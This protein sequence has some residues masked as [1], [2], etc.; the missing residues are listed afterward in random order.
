MRV[1]VSVQVSGWLFTSTVS[2]SR[3][4]QHMTMCMLKTHAM[5][6]ITKGA[7]AFAIIIV[8][9]AH[10]PIA[11]HRSHRRPSLSINTDDIRCPGASAE[12]EIN[13][14]MH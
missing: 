6:I 4:F 2:V 3:E 11:I 8:D 13:L 7:V 9:V 5:E 14:H 10:T 1:Q 12:T